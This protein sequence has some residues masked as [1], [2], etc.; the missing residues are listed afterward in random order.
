[1]DEHTE[2]RCLDP[3]P[4]KGVGQKAWSAHLREHDKLGHKM[5]CAFAPF[6]E[7][8]VTCDKWEHHNSPHSALGYEWLPSDNCQRCGEERGANYEH[9]K[10][11][12]RKKGLV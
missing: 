3:C 11:T 5:C 9:W 12:H 2:W 8:F 4:A 10:K 6:Y 7:G 1:M